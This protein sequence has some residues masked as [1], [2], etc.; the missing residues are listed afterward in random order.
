MKDVLG[1]WAAESEGAKFW[2]HVVTE[3]KN[4]GVQDIFIAG[5]DGVTG[6]PEAIE[7]V[8]PATHVQLCFVQLVRHSVR[9]V[10][11]TDRK[12]GALA[13][14]EI[15]QAA[16]LEA[17]ERQLVEL[18]A[19][20]GVRYPLIVR[21]WR[22]TWARSTPLV[23]YPREVRRASSTTTTIESLNMTVRTINKN[24]ALFPSAAVVFKLVSLALRN[25]SKKWTMPIRAWSSAMNQF[26]IMFEGRV[27]MGGLGTNTFTQAS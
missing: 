1:M 3:L 4:R 21:S 2:L 8:F 27:P 19:Q 22:A 25:I 18:E 26:A 12:A 5:V 10:A 14:K 17:A 23:G 16:T 6:F 15:Y 7:A 11:H 20:G 24:R 9:S 13:L